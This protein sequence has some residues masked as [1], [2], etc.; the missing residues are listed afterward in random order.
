[1]VHF[2]SVVFPVSAVYDFFQGIFLFFLM[3]F[4]VSEFAGFKIIHTY[5]HRPYRKKIKMAIPKFKTPRGRG[6]G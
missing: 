6:V 3:P 1:M 2:K 5:V 4:S